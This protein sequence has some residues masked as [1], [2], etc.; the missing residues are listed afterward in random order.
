M[1]DH[2]KLL[3]PQVQEELRPNDS[4]GPG[5]T[6]CNFPLPGARHPGTQPDTQEE[7]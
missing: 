1:Q 4:N 5:P 3:V 2:G 7:A 6:Q